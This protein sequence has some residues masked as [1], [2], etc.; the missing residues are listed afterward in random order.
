MQEN[1]ISNCGFVNRISHLPDYIFVRTYCNLINCMGQDNIR[2]KY[3]SNDSL[4]N[5]RIIISEVHKTSSIAAFYKIIK[6]II[7]KIKYHIVTIDR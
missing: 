7:Q 1:P 4:K 2:T 3:Q 5:R 6:G